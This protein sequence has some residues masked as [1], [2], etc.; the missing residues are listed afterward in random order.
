M[1]EIIP[2]ILENKFEEIERKVKEISFVAP[3]VQIDVVDGIY[4]EGKTWPFLKTDDED[5]KALVQ[6]DEALPEWED[7]SY[8]FDLMVSNPRAV[9][10]TFV[11]AGAS[12]IIVHYSSFKD[13][14]ERELFLRDF[15]K[16]YSL[17]DPLG[18]D[19]GLAIGTDIDVNEILKYKDTID[20][21]QLMG[22]DHIGKQGEK[23]NE[24]TIERVAELRKL[25]PEMIIQVDGGVG[26]AHINALV[27][28]GVNRV[29]EGSTIWSAD[30]PVEE[31]EHLLGLLE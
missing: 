5:L 4:A 9:A 19:L 25:L 15:K 28:A 2:A 30:D 20:F 27:G 14:Q 18:V 16:K 12:R 7:V 29:T 22:I 1:S 31:Y 24:K 21:V 6:E 11:M 10:D 13:E 23:F 17:P 26:E 3:C 8:E